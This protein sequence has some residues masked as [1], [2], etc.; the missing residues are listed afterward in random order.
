MKF[1][2]FDL[3]SAQAFPDDMTYSEEHF[4]ELGITCAAVAL[5]D[6]DIHPKWSL[7]EDFRFWSS[8][9]VE[10]LSKDDCVQIVFELMD[11]V[12]EDYIF[13]TWNGLSFD[14]KLLAVQSGMYY[15]CADIAYNHHIDM[16]L[17]PVFYKGHYVSLQKALDGMGSQGKLHDVVLSD[18]TILDNMTGEK[19]PELWAKGEFEAVLEYLSYDVSEPLG[20]LQFMYQKKRLQWYSK[21]GNMQVLLIPDIYIVKDLLY[22][23][24][25][26]EEWSKMGITR[27]QFIDWFPAGI[28]CK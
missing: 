9:T 15:E 1:A 13:V 6:S 14:F 4:K 3:E 25:D 16:M 26:H 10:R 24:K 17:F 20:L 23:T 19:A 2:S 12:K 18:G 7:T 22:N 8:D 21:K 28:I 27:A 11:L 5:A